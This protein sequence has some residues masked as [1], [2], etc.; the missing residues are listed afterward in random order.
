MACY[1]IIN[2]GASYQNSVSSTEIDLQ[3]VNGDGYADSLQTLDDNKLTVGENKQAD[4]NLLATV[5]NPLGGTMSMTYK[6]DGNTVDNPTR[7]GT[8]PRWRSNDGRPGDGVDVRRT[9][10]RPTPA[11]SSTV[12]TATRSATRRSPR[13]RSTAAATRHAVRADRAPVPQRQHVRRRVGD[14]HE[15]IDVANGGY[16]KGVRQTWSLR[17]V[18]GRRQPERAHT[19]ASLGYSTS[20]RC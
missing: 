16:I 6:R 13:P 9:D 8:W 17:D 15:V 2:P 12:C 1:L 3:D 20:P 7:C 5:N 14:Q 19:V 4:T 11:S 10:V 18:R